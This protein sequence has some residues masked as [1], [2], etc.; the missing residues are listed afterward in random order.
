MNTLIIIGAI[1]LGFIFG[2]I[3][4]ALLTIN[5][6]NEE[7]ANAFENGKA[8]ER[9]RAANVLEDDKNDLA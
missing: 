4:N 7:L 8:F 1:M 2:Y 6:H 9:M 5:T 3:S